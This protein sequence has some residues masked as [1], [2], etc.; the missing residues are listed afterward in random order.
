MKTET[1]AFCYDVKTQAEQGPG[2]FDTKNRANVTI[3]TTEGK[4]T[5]RNGKGDSASLGAKA[6]VVQLGAEAN[7]HVGIDSGAKVEAKAGIVAAE[8]GITMGSQVN[9]SPVITAACAAGLSSHAPE[10]CD[11]ASKT[12]YGIAMDGK[13][14]ATSG[15]NAGVSAEAG[16]KDKTVTVGGGFKGA[17]IAGPDVSFKLHAGGLESDETEVKK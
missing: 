15:L 7:A 12:A 14:G 16:Y 13:I 10:L 11:A 8:G 4:D 9:I 2:S 17:I 6:T 3:A 1:K 5:R